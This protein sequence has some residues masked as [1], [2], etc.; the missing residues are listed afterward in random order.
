MAG[1][2]VDKVKTLYKREWQ[3]ERAREAN[4]VRGDAL[5]QFILI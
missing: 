1:G 2:L 3:N 5:G 4:K